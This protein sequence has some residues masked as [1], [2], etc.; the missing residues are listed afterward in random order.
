MTYLRFI[1]RIIGVALA[2]IWSSAIQV[3]FRS[4]S[5]FRGAG[6]GAGY[7]SSAANSDAIFLTIVWFIP[8]VPFA[9]AIFGPNR[10]NFGTI[11]K[12]IRWYANILLALFSFVLGVFIVVRWKWFE[13]C[14]ILCFL[15][16]WNYC[17]VKNQDQNDDAN[18]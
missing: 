16:L 11:A 12:V 5:G 14:L 6:D 8:M 10:L 9:F 1:L 7:G 18:T 3:A 2:L 13:L 4:G 15:G 17:A